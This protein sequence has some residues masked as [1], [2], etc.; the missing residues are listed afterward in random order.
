[1]DKEQE[2]LKAEMLTEDYFNLPNEVRL[3]ISINTVDVK[4]FDYSFDERWQLLKKASN[5]A[6]KDLKKREFE[7]RQLK[8]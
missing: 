1:M 4:D 5:K 2:Y 8:K 3:R 7:I 6:Y